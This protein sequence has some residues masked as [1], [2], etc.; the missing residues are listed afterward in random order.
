VP[1]SSP[2]VTWYPDEKPQEQQQQQGAPP[3]AANTGAARPARPENLPDSYWDAEH[4]VKWD[5]VREAIAH[6]AQNETRRLTLP[7]DPKNYEPKLPDDFQAPDNVIVELDPSDPLFAEAQE[8]AFRW[9]R[10]E[11]SGQ[12]AFS[13]MLALHAGKLAEEQGIL[14]RG[15]SAERQKLGA[16]GSARVDAA[17]TWLQSQG[18]GGLAPLLFT[19]AGVQAVERLIQNFTSQGAGSFSQSHRAN[20]DPPAQTL[21]ENWYGMR[22]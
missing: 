11:V 1:R 3:S 2:T 8:L 10:G 9:D 6:K 19:A 5:Q 7:P 14:N 4:G 16:A 12:A 18:A 21:T 22:R 20:P 15:W 17:V 13:R